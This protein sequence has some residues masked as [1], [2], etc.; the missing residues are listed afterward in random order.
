MPMI[1]AWV[2]SGNDTEYRGVDPAAGR[3]GLP[4]PAGV[5]EGDA[6]GAGCSRFKDK[7]PMQPASIA[8]CLEAAAPGGG[9]DPAALPVAS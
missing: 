1:D 8:L 4:D 5:F 7:V 3:A 2:K 9:A 6:G